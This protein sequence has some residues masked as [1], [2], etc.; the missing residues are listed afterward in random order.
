MR[1]CYPS[2]GT[3]PVALAVELPI[4]LTPCP[5]SARAVLWFSPCGLQSHALRRTGKLAHVTPQLNYSAIQIIG[6]P[7]ERLR[8]VALIET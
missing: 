6:P 3:E 1:T 4:C 2:V 5:R 7:E 8:V